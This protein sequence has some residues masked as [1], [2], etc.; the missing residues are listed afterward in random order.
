MSLAHD[1]SAGTA[2]RR[3]GY[4]A[5]R[6]ADGEGR[7]SGHAQIGNRSQV[8]AVNTVGCGLATRTN[9]LLFGGRELRWAETSIRYATDFTVLRRFW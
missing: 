1:G 8:T 5:Q 2:Q 6:D 4:A 3:D 9:S 7:R